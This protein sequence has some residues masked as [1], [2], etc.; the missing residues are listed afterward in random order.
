MI[1]PFSTHYP[2]HMG[3]WAGQ[4]NYFPEKIIYGLDLSIPKKCTLNDLLAEVTNPTD[5]EFIAGAT[6]PHYGHAP[7]LHTIR[8]DRHNRWRAGRKIHPVINNRS[9]NQFQFAPSFDCTGVQQIE[10]DYS[11]Y[12]IMPDNPAPIV[13]IDGSHFYNPKIGID[14]GMAQLAQNDGFESID[15]FFAWFN[16]NYKGGIIHWTDL[17]Y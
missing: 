11:L 14:K 12:S 17:R 2:K 15:Q 4:P 9:K 6:N 3:E 5:V 13:V 1:L 10:I 16:N 8:Q 7:K